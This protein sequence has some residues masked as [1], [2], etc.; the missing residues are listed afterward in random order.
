MLAVAGDG[1][2]ALLAHARD[3]FRARWPT[4]LAGVALVA[5]VLVILLGVSGLLANR[6]FGRFV[7]GRLFNHLG[8]PHLPK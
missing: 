1:A 7:R 5:G 6:P 4:V 2:A 8:L 3:A